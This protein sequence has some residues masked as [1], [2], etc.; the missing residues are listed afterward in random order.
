MEKQ[1]NGYTVKQLARLA[2]V[3]VRTLHHYDQI[4]LLKPSSRTVAGYRLY[5]EDDL[6]RLQQ[7]LFFRELGLPLVEIPAILDQ[8]DFDQVKALEEHRRA[9]E[10]RAERLAHLLSTIDKTIRRLTEA[11]ME[12]TDAELY[13]GFTPEQVERYQ[14][15]ARELYDPAL[16]AESERRGRK[17][18]KAQWQAVKQEG[19]EVTRK[20]ASLMGRAPGE[21]GVQE[22]VARHHAWIEHFYTPTPEIYRGL[23]QLYTQNDEFRANYDRYRPGLADFMQAAMDYYCDHTLGG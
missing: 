20:M 18:S 2:G 1:K 19:D 3:S 11:D 16:V 4:G 17:M 12:M 8:P 13:E 15:E 7:I 14:R 21:A 9:L 22:T 10:Q 6:L 5:Q 23:G